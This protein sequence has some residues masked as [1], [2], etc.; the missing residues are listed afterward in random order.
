MELEADLIEELGRF[1]GYQ[2]IPTTLPAA[3]RAGI[4]AHNY[5]PESRCRR[6]LMGLG[7]T[8]AVNLSF[9][10]GNEEN[11]FEFGRR[12]AVQIRN[13]LNEDTRFLRT[14]LIPGLVRSARRNFNHGF[15][16]LRFFE[17]GKVYRQSEAGLPQERPHLGILGTGS[18]AGLNWHF[19]EVR[20][21]YFHL[22][23]VVEALMR[24]LRSEAVEIWPLSKVLWLNPADS[25]SINVGGI[26]IGSMGSLH[27]DLEQQFKFK[28]QIFVV[29]IDFA[30]L[31]GLVSLPVKFQPLSRY[32][33]VERDLSILVSKDL[34]YGEIRK[35][36]LS[37]GIRELASLELADIYSGEKIPRDRVSMMIRFFFQ[38]PEKT[39]TVDQVQ[40]HSDNIR[41]YL[42][43][44]Y[45]AELR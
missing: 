1:Y 33:G 32:P 23:G 13:P 43:T 44:K 21:D 4:P 41:S 7:Y 22:K 31:C 25:S 28:Q 36:I 35:G 16:S 30:E 5:E 24:G 40:E 17:I 29:E 45:G 11:A 14:S 18:A 38:D 9:S 10:H 37:M 42:R 2:N 15:R 20:Y 19:T 34:S 3:K 39:L 8:E 27:P 12:E 26:N 6:L